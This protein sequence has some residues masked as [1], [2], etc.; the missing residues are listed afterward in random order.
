MAGYENI[1][2]ANNNRT[3]EERREL[4]K[5]AGKAS[6]QARRR[7]ANLLKGEPLILPS[8]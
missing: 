4:A 5:I 7:K 1:R 6:G 3:P 8:E 2:D